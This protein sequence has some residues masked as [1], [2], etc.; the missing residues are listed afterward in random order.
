MMKNIRWNQVVIAFLLGSVVTAGILH[1]RKSF[2]RH[3]GKDRYA[4][5]L[6][7]FNR[8]LD[9][10]PEQR[11][12]VAQIFEDKRLKIEAIRNDVGPR[13]EEVRRNASEE[14]RRIL[15]PEQQVKFE[16][17]ERKHAEMRRRWKDGRGPPPR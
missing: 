11:T 7:R 16:E 12:K 9:L 10:T 5:M 1:C 3:D 8:T 14:I 13:F 6:D 15:T 4:K 2:W 17:M